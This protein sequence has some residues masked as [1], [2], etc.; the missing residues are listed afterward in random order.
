M[1][2]IILVVVGIILTI[3]LKGIVGLVVI[4]SSRI[5]RRGKTII[6]LLLQGELTIRLLSRERKCLRRL[7]RC[8]VVLEGVVQEQVTFLEGEE[9]IVTILGVLIAVEVVT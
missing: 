4:P 5:T 1:E 3:D 7:I 6:L 9:A 2:I 8:K